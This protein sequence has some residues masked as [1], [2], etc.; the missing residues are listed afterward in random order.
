[1]GAGAEP[2]TPATAG[3]ELADEIE[4][5]SGGGLEMRRQF[6]DRVAE[7]VQLSNAFR[8]GFHAGGDVWRGDFHGDASHVLRRL[9]TRVSEPPGS[10]QD[11]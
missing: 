2:V 10:A 4:E 3:V 9:Y 5:A 11:G 1:V 6:G 7:A 8:G